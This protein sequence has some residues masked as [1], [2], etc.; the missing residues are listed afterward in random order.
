L[1]G[2]RVVRWYLPEN[3]KVAHP[4]SVAPTGVGK[5]HSKHQHEKKHDVSRNPE[6][7]I[8]F[9]G[10]ARIRQTHRSFPALPL[11]LTLLQPASLACQDALKLIKSNSS[12]E[13]FEVFPHTIFTKVIILKNK[14]RKKQMEIYV[15][16]STATNQASFLDPPRSHDKTR[17]AAN[18]SSI[19]FQLPCKRPFVNHFNQAR[20]QQ[21]QNIPTTGNKNS[22]LMLG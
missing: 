16:T 19:I 10:G 7:W 21:K 8:G 20:I 3:S 4:R 9:A 22:K 5:C 14:K 11:N 18:M 13:G 1:E 17:S 2:G 6:N 15:S 12:L